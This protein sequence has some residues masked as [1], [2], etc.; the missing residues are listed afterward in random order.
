M[1]FLFATVCL[2]VVGCAG[3]T[4]N[5]RT[6]PPPGGGSTSVVGGVYAAGL[7]PSPLYGGQLALQ[8][9]IIDALWIDGAIRGGR[10]QLVID[11]A[12]VTSTTFGAD[13]GARLVLRTVV[14]D[15]GLVARASTDTAISQSVNTLGDISGGAHLALRLGPLVVALEPTVGVGARLAGVT[16]GTYVAR[17]PL[18]A[19]LQLGPIRLMAEVGIL[20]LGDLNNAEVVA[21]PHGSVGI[22]FDFGGGTGKVD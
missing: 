4:P 11:G 20:A 1:K 19:S 7:I 21:S 22:G 18:A 17:I 16:G 6:L 10:G 12:S 3:S 5:L 9:S 2:L 13:L 14:F 15:L 8:T